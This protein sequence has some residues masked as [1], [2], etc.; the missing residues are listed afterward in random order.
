M[1][2]KLI[3]KGGADW[4]RTLL[5]GGLSGIVSVVLV[6]L[7]VRR[8]PL[9]GMAQML[10]VALLTYVILRVFFRTF[11]S[12]IPQK[13]TGQTLDWTL[14]EKTLTLGEDTIPLES[15]RQVHCWPNRDAMGYDLPGWKVNIET[16]GKNRLLCT[17]TEGEEMEESVRRLRR[18]VAAL[19][20]GYNWVEPESSSGEDEA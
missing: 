9:S 5:V 11:S 19:G 7:L 2:G 18:L 8:L 10:V 16:S 20:Y 4:K 12:L 1:T 17:L 6:L 15:I 14:D 3:V 13:Q